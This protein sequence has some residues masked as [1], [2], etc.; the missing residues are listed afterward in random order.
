LRITAA[1]DDTPGFVEQDQPR[2]RWL[3][4]R[5]AIHLDAVDAWVGLVAKSSFDLIHLDAAFTQKLFSVSTRTDPCSCDQFLQPLAG[6]QFTP[7]P[8]SVI[9]VGQHKLHRLSL[10]FEVLMAHSVKLKT[11]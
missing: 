3:R 5:T 11:R 4:E 2:P 9:I 10:R 1:A 6:H 7:W 8:R